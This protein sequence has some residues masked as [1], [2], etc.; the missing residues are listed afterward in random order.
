[1][2][3]TG[4]AEIGGALVERLRIHMVPEVIR[5]TDHIGLCS[6]AD[7]GDMELGLYLYDIRESD[8]IRGTSMIMVDAARQKYPSSF[9]NLYYMVTAYSG[10]DS[11]YRAE[12]E[13]K[14]LGRVIQIFSDY[15]TFDDMLQG[16]GSPEGET[17]PTIVMQNLSLEDKLRAWTVPDVAYKTS[18]F[19]RV[20]PIEIDSRRVKD[21]QRVVD[22]DFTV[23]HDD[24]RE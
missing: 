22:V 6:P 15:A 3:H 11:K 9:F 14:I 5:S 13:Q 24:R 19:Y 1:M 18:L 23:K 21:T 16:V 20:G 17:A 8:E 7:K 4:I 12:E 2:R 10:S